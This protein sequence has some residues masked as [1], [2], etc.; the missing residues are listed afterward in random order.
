MKTYGLIGYIR[1]YEKY[2]G[3][4]QRVFADIQA[5]DLRV[6]NTWPELEEFCN[7]YN[8]DTCDEYE[9]KHIPFVVFLIQ[10]LKKYGKIPSKTSEEKEF[11]ELVKKMERFEKEENME[12][13]RNNAYHA[14][15]DKLN[16]NV[17]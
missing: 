13:A 16:I 2:H 10:A 9:H 5:I 6:G 8:L 4:I 11:K 7:K 12:E 3:N 15:S 14:F 17:R 1:L